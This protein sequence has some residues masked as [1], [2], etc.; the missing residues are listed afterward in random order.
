MGKDPLINIKNNVLRAEK[1][2]KARGYKKASKLYHKA[3]NGYMELNDYELAKECFLKGSECYIELKKYAEGLELLKLA[4]DAY[5]MMEQYSNANQLYKNALNIIPKLR[6]SNDRD[7]NYILFPV[8][9]YLCS[10]LEIKQESGLNF[11]KKYQ[12][13]VDNEFFK[14]NELIKMVTDVT[15]AIRDKNANL[16]EKIMESIGSFKFTKIETKLLKKVLVLSQLVIGIKSDLNLDKKLYTTNDVISLKLN[17]NTKIISELSNNAF[18]EYKFDQLK[19]TKLNVKLSD[20]LALSKKPDIP[21]EIPIDQSSISLD[22]ILKPH[23]QLDEPFIGPI[24]ITFEINETIACEYITDIVK[25]KLISP[26]PSLKISIK[27][28]KPPLI[29]QSFPLEILLENESNGDALDVKVLSKFPEQ[30]K[31]MRGTVEKQIYSL[32]P[33]EKMNWELN[34]KPEEVGDYIIEFDITFKDS[35]QNPIEL[36]QNFPFSITM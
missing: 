30:L 19:I 13:R 7:F 24:T 33:N 12:V 1:L 32:R 27:N 36:N 21:L 6:S 29:G 17:L 20:N 23:F 25:P 14:Q 5:L 34:I 18:F 11:I 15:L 16:I 10:F 28:L 9:S 35:D 8:L 22:F 26:P 31:V 2:Y 4:G 3:A